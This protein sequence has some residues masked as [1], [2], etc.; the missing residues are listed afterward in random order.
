MVLE[1]FYFA[2]ADSSKNKVIVADSSGD[3]SLTSQLPKL[4]NSCKDKYL[5]VHSIPSDPPYSSHVC[6][7]LLTINT[8]LNPR[9]SR[10][11]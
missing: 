4:I 11:Q 1:A 7:K 8:C 10:E 9:F 2:T 3:G 5:S 6:S